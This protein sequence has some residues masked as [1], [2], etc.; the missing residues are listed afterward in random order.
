MVTVHR[1]LCP[2]DFSKPSDEAVRV[3]SDLASQFSAELVLVHV[4]SPWNNLP[5]Y[6]IANINWHSFIKRIKEQAE[7]SIEQVAHAK[8]PENVHLRTKI[9]AGSAAGEIVKTDDGQRG[10]QFLPAQRPQ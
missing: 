4:L 8:V 3:A 2:T 7:R 5:P 10:R 1:I 9:V 6:S